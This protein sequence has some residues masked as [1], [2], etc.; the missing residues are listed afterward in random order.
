MQLS[1]GNLSGSVLKLEAKQITTRNHDTRMQCMILDYMQDQ[2][3]NVIK[4]L[5]GKLG[6]FEY[7]QYAKKQYCIN[8]KCPECDNY[9][10]VL[11]ENILVL[12]TLWGK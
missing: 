11:W 4:M 8:I 7:G 3:K 12:G 2:E 5:L 1:S 9:I 6:D 10:M